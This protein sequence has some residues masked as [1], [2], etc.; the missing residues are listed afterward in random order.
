[1]GQDTVRLGEKRA[2]YKASP[3]CRGSSKQLD[4]VDRFTAQHQ[5]VTYFGLLCR[6]ALHLA[7]AIGFPDIVSLLVGRHCE[8][9][10]CDNNSDTPLIKD[11]QCQQEECASILLLHGAE[12]KAVDN[13]MPSITLQLGEID[14]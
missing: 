11:V 8:L 3:P 9:N 12:P 7:C 6:T 5:T 14:P 13:S 2:G 1:M 4:S 10:G